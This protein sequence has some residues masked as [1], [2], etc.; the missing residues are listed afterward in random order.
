MPADKPL[1]AL[2]AL[3]AAQAAGLKATILVPYPAPCPTIG[4][5]AG[6]L[7]RLEAKGALAPFVV[8]IDGFLRDDVGV[9]EAAALLGPAVLCNAEPG[10]GYANLHL[11]PRAANVRSATLE[12][13][14]GELIGVVV[15]VEPPVVVDLV[16]LS[17]RY[18]ALRSLPGLHGPGADALDPETKAFRGMLTF[19]RRDFADPLAARKVHQIIYRRTSMLEILPEKFRT[20]ADV[21]RLVRLA[22]RPKAPD[23]VAFY[24]TLGVFDKIAGD[25]VSFLPA[26]AMRNVAFASI[27]KTTV[28][29]RHFVRSMKVTLASPALGDAN[30]LAAALAPDGGPKPT[31]SVEGAAAV[32]RLAGGTVRVEPARGAISTVV[33]DRAE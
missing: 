12:T 21:A 2:D 1:S 16:A 26:Q 8:D 28:G 27:T 31:A 4:P 5:P 11:A 7:S 25:D 18:G 14:D 33:I 24:G 30:A 15:E 17:K 9:A 13:H 29:K 22:L 32:L 20:A 23:S 19:D 10:S 3:K 6:D